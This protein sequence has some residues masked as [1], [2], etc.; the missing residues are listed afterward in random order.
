MENVKSMP[1]NE[2]MEVDGCGFGCTLINTDVF[3]SIGQLSWF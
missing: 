3:R 1:E 2:F